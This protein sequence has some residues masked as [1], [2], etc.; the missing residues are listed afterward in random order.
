M[1]SL[2]FIAVYFSLIS[3]VLSAKPCLSNYTAAVYEHVTFFGIENK[4][5]VTRPGALEIM[6]KNLAVFQTK[7]VLAKSKGAQIIIFPED[8]LYGFDYKREQIFPFLE[9]IPDPSQLEKSWNPC[10]DPD[11]FKD[12]EVLRELSCIAHN[13][14][15]AVV[16]NM[17]DVQ[18][19]NK[20]DP[21]CP[22]DGRYQ[23]NT[24]VVFDT[25]GTLL[26]KYHKQH[27]YHEDQFNT[28]QEAE[29]VI[30]KTSFGVTFGVFTCFD[31]L[32][33]DPAIEL[34]QK[35]GVRNIVFPT[36]WMD[37]FPILASVEYQQG[38]SR[39]TCVN[40]LAA[41]Q[42][43]PLVDM[44]G[45]GIYSCGEALSYVYDMKT[46]E[47][48]LLVASLPNLEM[49]TEQP[50]QRET[51]QSNKVPFNLWQ[52][53]MKQEESPFH[54]KLLNDI[55]TFVKIDGTQGNASVCANELCCHASYILPSQQPLE[56]ELFALGAFNGHHDPEGYIIQACVLIK[57]SSME[58]DSCGSPTQTSSTI[59]NSFQLMGNFSS[60]A[61]VFPEVLASGVELIP[62]KAMAISGNVMSVNSF[63]KPLLSAVLF[64]RIYEL[65]NVKN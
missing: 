24:D 6:K 22:E 50:I 52:Y 7:A 20:S 21:H 41:N 30:F 44:V 26:A 62:A 19:C 28:P 34:V 8:G 42:H 25:D 65:D 61:Y 47:G 43:L 35:F 36:A 54:S 48:H 38:W 37:G 10:S 2:Q 57:C 40:L 51:C 58:K 45:S 1:E 9:I 46:Y 31:M 60:K 14:S 32:F 27:L 13:S 33:Y 17:G 59:F 56:N 29:I 18:Y 12:T 39:L 55:Y 63:E 5:E 53:A 3:I 16:A 15:I 11:R 4:T 23:F 64:G 49:H